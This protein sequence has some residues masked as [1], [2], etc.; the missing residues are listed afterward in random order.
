MLADMN[1]FLEDDRFT[2]GA[3]CITIGSDRGIDARY[4]A[5]EAYIGLN[6][7]GPRERNVD[8]SIQRSILTYPACFEVL[9]W[10]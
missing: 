6:G 2:L 5:S 1:C 8:L 3:Q 10:K 7:D 4:V 9:T